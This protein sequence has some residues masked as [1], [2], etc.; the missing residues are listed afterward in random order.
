MREVQSHSTG[1]TAGSIPATVA[2]WPSRPTAESTDLKSAK[3]GFE[4]RLGYQFNMQLPDYIKPGAFVRLRNGKKA[5]I[6]EINETGSYPIHGAILLSDN[7]W[8][9]REWHSE[10]FCESKKKSLIDIV[11]PWTNM[12]DCSELWSQLP[13]WINWVAMDE[14]GSWAGYRNKPVKSGSCYNFESGYNDYCTIPKEYSPK[15]SGSWENSL[16]ER[17]V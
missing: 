16:T 6:Y 3:C 13:P 10:F 5:K 17:P 1:R 4:S 15:Y 7:T 12:P 2:I 9:M 14:N 11:G 8:Y